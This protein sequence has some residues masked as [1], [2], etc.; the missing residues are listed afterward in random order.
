MHRPSPEQNLSMNGSKNR[1]LLW[2]GVFLSIV[3]AGG[4]YYVSSVNASQEGA[5][6]A[7]TPTPVVVKTVKSEDVRLWTEFSGRL[8]AVDSAEIRP[9]V[10][11]RI[12]ELRFEDGQ[13]VKAGEVLLV[14]DPRPYEAALA[15]A[16]AN[17]ATAQTNAEFSRKEEER[18]AG[19]IKTQAIAQRL[20]DERKNARQVAE[21]SVKAAKA[22]VQ[23]ARLNLEYANVRAPISGRVSRA[24]ITVGNLVQP[25]NDAPMLTRIVSDNELYAD[26][27][28]DEQTYI[29]SIRNH[30]NGQKQERTIPVEMRLQ[31]DKEKT[32][33]GTIHSFD[34]NLNTASG[35]IRAR[36]KFKNTDGALMPGMF[37]TV[38]LANSAESKALLVPERAIG[39]DQDKKFVLI[40][41][42]NNKV[43]YRE[44]ELG[45]NYQTQRIVLK[46]LQDGDRVIVNGTQHVRPEMP[47]TPR[48]ATPED[49]TLAKR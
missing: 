11:G 47:V 18:A 44:I 39:F 49:L 38:N 41:D 32:Y 29:K 8:R 14:I 2:I 12:T 37:V 26:F 28:V 25:G 20:Y 43:A 9:E 48:E 15:R 19:M 16:E 7:S 23:Q 46:G 13:Q 3:I 4:G 30:A 45:K 24:E 33:R 1:R 27:E 31:G 10:S 17:L 40:V 5:D 36:A 35:T 21:A 22:E 34:N 6:A 42:K